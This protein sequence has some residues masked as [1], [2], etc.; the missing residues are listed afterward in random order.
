MHVIF[1]HAIRYEWFERENPITKVRQ[2][3]A[4]EKRPTVLT[5]EQINR[6]L[7]ELNGFHRFMVHLDVTTGLRGCELFALQWHDFDFDEL[8]TTVSRGIVNGV[9]GTCKTRFSNRVVPLDPELANELKAM[10]ERRP[11]SAGSDFVFASPHSKGKRPF[12][13]RTILR[14]HIR[15]AL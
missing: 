7:G 1:S 2:S 5:A 6:L 15:P 11:Y 12:C 8:T 4:P 3:S 9:V 13:R 14:N 10:R